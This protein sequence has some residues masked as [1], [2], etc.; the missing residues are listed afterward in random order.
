MISTRWA[1]QGSREEGG[2]AGGGMGEACVGAAG[3]QWWSLCGEAGYRG[4]Q[5]VGCGVLEG[6]GLLPRLAGAN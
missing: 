1:L 6:G 4:Y 3:E 2:W 5:V